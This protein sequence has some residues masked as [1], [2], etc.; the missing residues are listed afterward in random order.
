[1]RLL[2][3]TGGCYGVLVTLPLARLSRQTV[4]GIMMKVQANDGTVP[5]FFC[6]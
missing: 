2:R 3:F 5:S 6:R 1:M 4:N